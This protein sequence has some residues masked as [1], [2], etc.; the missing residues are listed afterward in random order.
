MNRRRIV[1]KKKNGRKGYTIDLDRIFDNVV[2]QLSESYLKEVAKKKKYPLD[3]VE[4]WVYEIASNFAKQSKVPSI[5]E[6]K[7]ALMDY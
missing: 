2:P 1:G 4:A 3:E 7:K 6:F 5:S